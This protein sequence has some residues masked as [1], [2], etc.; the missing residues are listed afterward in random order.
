MGWA[1]AYVE[2]KAKPVG[3]PAIPGRAR[4]AGC[5][6]APEGRRRRNRTAGRKNE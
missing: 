5:R 6:G 4:G 1:R 3:M 2:R